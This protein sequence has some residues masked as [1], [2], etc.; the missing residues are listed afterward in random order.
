MNRWETTPAL[1]RAMLFGALLVGGA[2]AF[3]EPLLV[4]LAAP[5]IVH[6]AYAL[7]NRPTSKP[8]VRA[9]LDHVS[10]YEGQGTR[11]RLHVTEADGVEQVTRISSQA[12]YVALHPASGRVS[13]PAARRR[14]GAGGQP[15]A[16][17]AADAG[18]GEGGADQ[19]LGRLP[20]GAG[21]RARRSR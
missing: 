14:A 13:G 16:L 12:P 7:L 6:A 3:G 19:R 10:L 5:L 18:G 11:S 1:S 15:A 20:L 21:A 17:G 8:V 2:V 4:V 9:T